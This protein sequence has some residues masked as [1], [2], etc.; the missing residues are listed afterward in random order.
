MRDLSTLTNR[1]LSI[2]MYCSVKKVNCFKSLV[3]SNSISLISK[4]LS[5]HPNYNLHHRKLYPS[6]YLQ[7]QGPSSPIQA[8]SQ[9]TLSN[10][11]KSRIYSISSSNRDLMVSL[12][13]TRVRARK[14]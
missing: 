1:Q 5:N 14:Q 13:G 12:K 4:A 10:S 11:N 7:P 3:A 2:I 9:I 8:L 6:P